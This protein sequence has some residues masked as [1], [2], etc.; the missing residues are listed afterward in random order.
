M[1]QKSFSE[2]LA[3]RA[4]GPVKP[5]VSFEEALKAAAGDEVSE[6]E[7]SQSSAGYWEDRGIAG[8]VWHPASGATEGKRA[9]VQVLGVPPELAALGAGAVG[10]AVVQPG[11]SVAGRLAAG[12]TAAA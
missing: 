9:D 1:P 10:R 11:L 6:P 2:A 4:S 3:E 7:P 5:S 8:K 12:A